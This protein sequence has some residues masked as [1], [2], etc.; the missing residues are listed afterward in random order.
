MSSSS[1][2]NIHIP[3]GTPEIHLIP[4]QTTSDAFIAC[5]LAIAFKVPAY[6]LLWFIFLMSLSGFFVG[7]VNIIGHE[8]AYQI[9][10]AFHESILPGK[11]T[12]TLDDLEPF[13]PSI[14]SAIIQLS[15][16]FEI[17]FW[18]L[19]RNNE[20]EEMCKEFTRRLQRNSILIAGAYVVAIIIAV[21]TSSFAHDPVEISIMSISASLAGLYIAALIANVFFVFID[22]F[23][24]QLLWHAGAV[25]RKR[26]F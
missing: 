12:I 20:I 6:C 22:T 9:A 24:H 4:A 5:F 8:K 14:L 25:L 18:Y 23:T 16:I 3:Q 13:F 17:L 11:T 2:N 19:T 15:I 10:L 1:P 26:F 7:C 21:A